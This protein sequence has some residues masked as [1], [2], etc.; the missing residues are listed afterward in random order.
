M[1]SYPN[2]AICQLSHETIYR[3]LF[4][5]SRGALKKELLEGHPPI[6]D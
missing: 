4:I 3:T 2:D 6:A 1:R 5:Q